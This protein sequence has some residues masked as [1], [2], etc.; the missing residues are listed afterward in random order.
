VYRDLTDDLYGVPGKWGFRRCRNDRLWWLNPRPLPSELPKVYRRYHTHGE[1]DLRASK[2]GR[3][4]FAMMP[5][6]ARAPWQSIR[7]IAEAERMW[8]PAKPGR[9]LDVGAG[10]GEFVAR[11]RG[12]G[13]DARGVEPDRDAVARA[14]ERYGVELDVGTVEDVE[15]SERFDA[16]TLDN[17]IEHVPD[18]ID[19]LRQCA[20]RLAKGGVLLLITPNA[21]SL[22]EASYGVRWRGLE[23]PRHLHIFAP[24]S[25]RAIS[26]RAELT[27]ALIRTTPRALPFMAISS[28]R[29]ATAFATLPLMFTRE[30]SHNRGE[31]LLVR[32]TRV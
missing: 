6:F 31:E 2:L 7:D 20:T 27:N 26:E 29:S 8:L 3:L 21:D 14:R 13:W 5:L 25:M 12:E 17:V 11:M 10:D 23:P 22:G 32:H 19:T 24:A 9:L 30:A 15:P 16:I 28:L 1:S 4:W 18:P